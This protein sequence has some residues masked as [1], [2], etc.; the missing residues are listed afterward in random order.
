MIVVQHPRT[1][2]AEPAPVSRSTLQTPEVRGTITDSTGFPMPGVSVTLK[3]RTS[4]GTSTDL[5][6]KYILEIPEDIQ[7]PVLVFGILGFETK[8][9]PVKGREVVNVVIVEYSDQLEDVVVV[10]IGRASCR[11]RVCQSV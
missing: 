5:N 8:E 2:D 10:E 9:V 1:S 11:E 6:G 7:S 3:N 4:V